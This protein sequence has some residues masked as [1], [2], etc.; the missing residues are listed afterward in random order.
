VGIVQLA[1]QYC[2]VAVNTP[3][4][5]AQLLPGVTLNSSLFGAAGTAPGV[6]QV[7]SALAARVLGTGLATQPAASSV[8][9]ELN[10]MIGKLCQSTA[11]ST[12]ARVMAVT[13]AACAAA[14]SSADMLIN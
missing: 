9:T 4:L 10:A 13:S 3:A 14:F 6:N 12:Q 8:T 1:I 2:N 11:C 7:S 5:A